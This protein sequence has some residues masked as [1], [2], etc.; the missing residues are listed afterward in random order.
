MLARRR[1]PWFLVAALALATGCHRHTAAPAP[2]P[3][4]LDQQ[5]CWWT[6][7]RSTLPPDSVG[8]RFARAFGAQ[9]YTVDGPRAGVDTTIFDDQRRVHEPVRGAVLT[10]ARARGL[11]GDAVDAMASGLAVA[12]VAADTTRIR[13]YVARTPALTGAESIARCQALW[14]AA[15]GTPAATGSR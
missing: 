5:Y 10:F 15:M 9:G 2:V 1:Y 8:A 14:R 7:L 4:A 13:Y 6:S 12:W 11:P 3:I